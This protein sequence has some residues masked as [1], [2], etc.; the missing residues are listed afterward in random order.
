MFAGALAPVPGGKGFAIAISCANNVIKITI[1]KFLN[2][3]LP[4]IILTIEKHLE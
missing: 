2:F 1:R 4:K 3:I